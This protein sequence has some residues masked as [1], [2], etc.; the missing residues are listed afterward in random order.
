MRNESNGGTKAKIEED[1]AI[2]RPRGR[3]QSNTLASSR[4]HLF[5]PIVAERVPLPKDRSR[6]LG[7]DRTMGM[8]LD[9]GDF[10]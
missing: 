2:P 10:R 4:G 8:L 5:S 3:A 9:G 6:F 1:I 7:Q